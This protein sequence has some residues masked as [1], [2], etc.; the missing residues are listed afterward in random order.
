M[1]HLLSVALLV[2]LFSASI[3]AQSAA[4]SYFDGTL[5]VKFED[6]DNVQKLNPAMTREVIESR[7]SDVLQSHGLISQTQLWSDQLDQTFKRTHREK[8]N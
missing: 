7:V 2:A 5:I 6:F 8:E 1:R 3:N 4:P